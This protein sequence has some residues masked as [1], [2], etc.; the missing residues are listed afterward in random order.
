LG[1]GSWV[2]GEA[3]MVLTRITLISTNSHLCHSDWSEE[4]FALE[5][6]KRDSSVAALLQNDSTTL[7]YWYD[8]NFELS[9]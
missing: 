2:N 1:V 4:S 7:N 3:Q 8:C 5:F 9:P 6:E